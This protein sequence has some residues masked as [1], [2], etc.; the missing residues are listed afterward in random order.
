MFSRMFSVS[1]SS[2]TTR[3]VSHLGVWSLCGLLLGGGGGEELWKRQVCI[4]KCNRFIGGLVRIRLLRSQIQ[5]CWCRICIP[6]AIHL[7]FPK[8]KVQVCKTFKYHTGG[9]IVVRWMDNF[10]ICLPWRSGWPPNVKQATINQQFVWTGG[11]P[12]TTFNPL[13]KTVASGNQ[14]SRIWICILYS[15]WMEAMH[16]DER[17]EVSCSS[18]KRNKAPWWGSV[19]WG[20]SHGFE[21]LINQHS[22]DSELHRWGCKDVETTVLY[23][24]IYCFARLWQFD[25][26][27]WT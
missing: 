20:D 1:W 10:I 11:W 6:S 16:A 25:D 9:L 24:R 12:F 21:L 23:I 14:L 8:S 18:C 19:S 15:Q 26:S 4:C 2:E 22:I 27:L 7:I 3:S 13:S 5:S 17:M